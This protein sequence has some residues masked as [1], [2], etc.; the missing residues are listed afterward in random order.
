[1]H[2]LLSSATA[3]FHEEALETLNQIED[4]LLTSLESSTSGDAHWQDTL[5]IMHSLKGTAA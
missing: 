4:W 3:A 1:M 2:P 5:R